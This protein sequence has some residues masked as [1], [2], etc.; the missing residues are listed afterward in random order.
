MAKYRLTESRLRNMIREA[1]QSVLTEYGDSHK[2]GRYGAAMDAYKKAMSQG[3]TRQANNFKA[4]AKQYFNDDYGFN[5]QDGQ[6]GAAE[7]LDDALPIRPFYN[8]TNRVQGDGE[9]IAVNEP[10]VNDDAYVNAMDK[11]WNLRANQR[12][13]MQKGM[14]TWLNTHWNDR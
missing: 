6:F 7:Y 8:D 10:N 1:V 4:F 5:N 3:R 12:N 14:N 11:S 13:R 9:H 2:N